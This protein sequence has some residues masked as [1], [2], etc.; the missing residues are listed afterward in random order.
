[1]VNNWSYSD[2]RPRLQ[3]NQATIVLDQRLT[4]DFYGLGSISVFADAFYSHQHGK[5][6]YPPSN[7][8]ARQV[9]NVNLA[10]PTSSP[11]YP[12]GPR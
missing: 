9:P 12:T 8:E 3:S 10:V 4:N 1:L 6:V 2:A 7:G 11:F 5:Q